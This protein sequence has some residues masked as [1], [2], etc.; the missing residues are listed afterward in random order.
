MWLSWIA[1]GLTLIGNVILIRN[2][3]WKAFIIFIIGNGIFTYY[4]F[5]KHEWATM[6]LVII[7]LGQNVWGLIT[8]RKGRT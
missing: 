8:W 3:S 7:F 1:S 5:I 4:W 2:K 6:I